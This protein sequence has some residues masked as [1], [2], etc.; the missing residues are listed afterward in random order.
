MSDFFHSP[1]GLRRWCTSLSIVQQE[2][3]DLA[4]LE[5]CD[6]AYRVTAVVSSGKIPQLINTFARFFPDDAFF[7]LEYYP[8]P[9]KLTANRTGSIDE[10]PAPEVF[11]SH[12]LPVREIMDTI[13]PYMERLIHDGFVGFGLANNKAGLEVFFSE[14]KVLTFFTDNHLRLSDFLAKQKVPYSPELTLPTDFGHDHLS[15]LGLPRTQLPLSLS[16]MSDSELDS[17]IF[18][19]QLVEQLE[20]YPVEEGLSFFL[21]RKEQ[22]LVSEVIE[23]NHFEG[24]AEIE[25]GGLLLDWSDFVSECTKGFDGD[26]E[27]YQHALRIR[28]CIQFVMENVP[29]DLSEKIGHIVSEPDNGFKKLLTDRRK[30]LDPPTRPEFNQERFWYHGVVQKQGTNLRRDLIRKGW[31]A[32]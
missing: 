25:F 32:S 18:C 24:F 13:T 10:R 11:Y 6:N 4:L 15:L 2:G 8:D 5:D 12:Y 20:M 21:T 23:K 7:I 28:D 26:L 30:R 16:G 9:E 1:V 17:T 27:E 29:Q 3:Y 22:S 14:E 31:F 19:Q